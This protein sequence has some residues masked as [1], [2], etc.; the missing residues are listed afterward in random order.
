MS[1]TG[2]IQL[3]G[4][5]QGRMLREGRQFGWFMTKYKFKD[6]YGCF[7]RWRTYMKHWDVHGHAFMAMVASMWCPQGQRTGHK[8][9]WDQV[10]VKG[11]R[12]WYKCQAFTW[13]TRRDQLRAR[14]RH[15][16]GRAFGARDF[17][18]DFVARMVGEDKYT[19]SPSA[20]SRTCPMRPR[21]WSPE[22]INHLFNP[23]FV[24]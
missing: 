10:E 4:C 11:T 14:A 18:Q 7:G 19:V 21:V 3:I 24:V 15:P 1:F 12:A 17:Y 13:R 6:N 2:N 8:H 5:M 16:C 23:S 9:A 22:K 20:R